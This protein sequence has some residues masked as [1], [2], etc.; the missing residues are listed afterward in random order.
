M[1]IMSKISL[2]L[3]SALSYF[4]LK[5]ATCISFSTN[6]CEG[7]KCLTLLV[8]TFASEN[9]LNRPAR[10]LTL[11]ISQFAPRA[12]IR[13]IWPYNQQLTHAVSRSAGIF[14]RCTQ[15]QGYSL[16]ILQHFKKIYSWSLLCWWE[17]MY[18]SE[19][20]TA[21]R[22]THYKILELTHQHHT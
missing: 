5:I 16:C 11:C 3:T 22:A 12:E 21:A 14:C 2:N 10:E 7:G 18:N 9:H 6:Y 8:S 4:Q 1:Q 15:I 17:L 19:L 20:H 13:V